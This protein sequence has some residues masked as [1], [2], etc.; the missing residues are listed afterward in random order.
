MK[1]H[2]APDPDGAARTGADLLAGCIADAV[3]R[4]GIARVGVSGGTSPWRLLAHLAATPL[5]WA[6]VRFVQVDERLVAV[7]DPARNLAAQTA[8]LAPALGAGAH[9]WSLAPADPTAPD[10]RVSAAD[11]LRRACGRPALFDVVHLG[12]GDDGHTAGLPPDRAAPPDPHAEIE[13]IRGFRGHDRVTLTL[14]VL[15]RARRRL[16][17]VTGPTKRAALQTLLTG[18]GTSVAG[19][20]VRR[21]SVVVA[22]DAA[23]G[24]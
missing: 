18:G 24:P 20:V 16:W 1:L 9:L 11:R 19:R 2:R 8:A 4:R 12:L 6:R 10:P 3:A 7:D 21:G 14:A 17:F 5:P 13:V 23:V 15:N 22:D